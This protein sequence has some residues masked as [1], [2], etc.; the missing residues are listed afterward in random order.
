MKELEELCPGKCISAHADG[1]LQ[2]QRAM[3]IAR[4]S[5]GLLRPNPSFPPIPS[6]VYFELETYEVQT[7]L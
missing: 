7:I 2:H 3:H 5:L 6:L 4:T 1:G